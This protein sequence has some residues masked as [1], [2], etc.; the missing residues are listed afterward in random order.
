MAVGDFDGDTRSDFAV[1]RPTTGGLIWYMLKSNYNYGFDD[2]LQWGLSAGDTVIPADFDGDAVT[3]VA[4]W[5]GSTGV[6]YVRRSSDSALQSFQWGAASDL[7][8]PADFDGDY[9]AD[10]AVYRQ[11]Q[12]IWYI[13]NS[14]TATFRYEAFGLSTDVPVSAPYRI[15]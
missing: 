5:R 10:Y 14:S 8:Q 7:P 11:S 15:Q 13:R 1:V 6:F 3:D 2:A 12:G 9:K 4:V